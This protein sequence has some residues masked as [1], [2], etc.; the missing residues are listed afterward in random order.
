MRR[1]LGGAVLVGLVFSAPAAAAPLDKVATCLA[2]PC[3]PLTKP[4]AERAALQLVSGRSANCNVLDRRTAR[5]RVV[6]VTI[7]PN[8]VTVDRI[9]FR[10]RIRRGEPQLLPWR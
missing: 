7:T 9:G 2:Q 3:G 10:V 5:C 6:R 4:D 1:L 8:L